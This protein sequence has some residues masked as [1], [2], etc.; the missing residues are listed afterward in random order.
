MLI[1]HCLSQDPNSRVTSCS[2]KTGLTPQIWILDISGS[3]ELPAIPKP[4][5][6]AAKD[7]GLLH[8]SSTTRCATLRGQADARKSLGY[9]RDAIE[10]KTEV[11][12]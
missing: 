11:R 3:R 1:L 9:T 6:C 2:L 12:K 10:S 7:F 5:E 4:D 8:S